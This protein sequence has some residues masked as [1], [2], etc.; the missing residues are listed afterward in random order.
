MGSTPIQESGRLARF[1]VKAPALL[2]PDESHPNRCVRTETKNIS[3]SGFYFLWTE[4]DRPIGSV[5][6]FEVRIPTGCNL[7]GYAKVARYDIRKS[8][9]H[10][11]AVAIDKIKM[12]AKISNEGP[13]SSAQPIIGLPTYSSPDSARHGYVKARTEV[14]RET[15]A[16]RK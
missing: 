3:R 8:Q 10:G 2:W 12:S 14:T 11:F 6:R 9:R 7:S 16:D 5:I 4:F 13:I 1:E 15:I